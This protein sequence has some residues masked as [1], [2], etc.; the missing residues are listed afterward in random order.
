M[1]D[2]ILTLSLGLVVSL[3]LYDRLWIAAGG[4][5]VPGYTAYLL[6]KPVLLVTSL[7]AGFAAYLMLA[8]LGR[9]SILYGRRRFVIAILMGL[10]ANLVVLHALRY[11]VGKPIAIPGFGYVMPGLLASWL[12]KQGIVAT[13]SVLTIATVATGLIV[14][15]LKSVGV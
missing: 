5:V 6:D 8:G 12:D 13:S 11:A 1:S 9:Y 15:F 14:M 3:I 2:Y 10:L 7:A 4:V